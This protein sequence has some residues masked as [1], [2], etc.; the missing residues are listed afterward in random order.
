[1]SLGKVHY[2]LIGIAIIMSFCSMWV[3]TGDIWLSL[4]TATSFP[5]LILM[6]VK[7]VSE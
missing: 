2:I 1:M 5:L 7:I 3:T 4:G 6:I